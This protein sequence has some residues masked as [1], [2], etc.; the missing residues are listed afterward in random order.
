MP[1]CE[2]RLVCTDPRHL[3][4]ETGRRQIA[5]ALHPW[6]TRHVAT[7]FELLHRPDLVERLTSSGAE[8]QHAIQKVAVPVALAQ[9][10]GVHELIR[11]LHKVVDQ[12][13]ARLLRDHATGVLPKVDAETFSDACR[14][15]RDAPDGGF[16]LAAGV[17]D[18]MACA[19]TMDGKALCLLD[20]WKAAPS[21]G[22]ARI[23]AEETL[24][25]PLGEILESQVGISAMAG[26]KLERGEL[27]LTLLQ[28]THGAVVEA[29]VQRFPAW[30][31]HAPPPSDLGLA[32]AAVF[33][34]GDFSGLRQKLSQRILA[35]V[36]QPG[37]LRPGDARGEVELTRI[38]AV[39]LTAASNSALPE[40]QV[41][42]AI[43][44]RMRRL[45]E[46]P[47][48]TTLLS[49]Q[50]SVRGEMGALLDLFE[51]LVGDANRVRGLRI[52]EEK[53]TSERFAAELLDPSNDPE[54]LIHELALIHRRIARTGAGVAGAQRLQQFIG[55]LAGRIDRRHAVTKG[56]ANA[57]MPRPRKLE[58]LAR[59]VDGQSAPPGPVAEQAAAFLKALNSDRT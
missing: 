41:R 51:C 58:L 49:D 2:D 53:A 33:S 46:P 26:R 39:L 31:T 21:E 40:E 14:T 6:L 42:E 56:L 12:A 3:Y 23:F 15:L 9:K 28:L 17:A 52:L 44:E 54:K 5:A 55:E 38:L 11:T 34:G 35:E 48:V 29:V 4:D 16:L 7:P 20:L 57:L 47:F 43:I 24:E 27:V 13:T 59:M 37:R 32:L 22:A 45:V 19:E 50:E 8:L 18:H 30:N 25:Q 36:A 10:A 1:L